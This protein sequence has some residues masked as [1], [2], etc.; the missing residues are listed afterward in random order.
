VSGWRGICERRDREK[1]KTISIDDL[2]V[3]YWSERS[4][5]DVD[6]PDF[7]WLIKRGKGVLAERALNFKENRSIK[8]LGGFRDFL[9]RESERKKSQ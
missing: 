8:F 7:F 9:G 2:R 5:R 4:E 1:E 6:S 3:V